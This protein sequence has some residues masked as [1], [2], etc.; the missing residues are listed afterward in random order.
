VIS[1]KLKM[2]V[3]TK[4]DSFFESRKKKKDQD[5]Q[6]QTMAAQA[7][8]RLSMSEA[9]MTDSSIIAVSETEQNE[10]EFLQ[11]MSLAAI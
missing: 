9:P 8:A 5:K 6:L 10:T 2:R 11:A 1:E 7:F 4:I 3:S